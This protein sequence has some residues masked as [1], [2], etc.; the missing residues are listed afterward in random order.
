ML[1]L[2]INGQVYGFNFGMGFMREV[3]KSISQP[4]DGMKDVKQNIGLRYKVAGIIDGDI[5]ALVDVLL[6]ANKGQNPRVTQM[7]LDS[8]ID[9]ESTDVDALFD[10]VLDFLRNAN[11]TKKTTLTILEAVERERAKQAAN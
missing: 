10:E 4:V 11:A 7:L 1:E 5:E 3:N 2:T 8:Y 9:D 6:A